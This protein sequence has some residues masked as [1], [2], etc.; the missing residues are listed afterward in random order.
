MSSETSDSETITTT[1]GEG[2]ATRKRNE[3][4]G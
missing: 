1:I 4:N 3:V 2:N